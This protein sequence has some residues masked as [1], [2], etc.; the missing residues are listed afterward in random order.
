MIGKN[1]QKKRRLYLINDYLEL[2]FNTAAATQ[3]AFKQSVR[4]RRLEDNVTL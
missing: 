1:R 4:G 3:I 2:V